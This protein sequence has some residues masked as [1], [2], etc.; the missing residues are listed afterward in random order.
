M[1]LKYKKE[2]HV[3]LKRKTIR[4]LLHLKKHKTGEVNKEEVPSSKEMLISFKLEPDFDEDNALPGIFDF[5][6]HIGSSHCS[7]HEIVDCRCDHIEH[8]F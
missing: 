7:H 8:G 5:W 4:N 6:E 1:K 2:K 3:K